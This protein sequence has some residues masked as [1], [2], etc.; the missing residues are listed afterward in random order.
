MTTMKSTLF[1]FLLLAGLAAFSGLDAVQAQQ[2][3]SPASG[4]GWMGV[5]LGEAP[6]SGV[7]I[8]RV[9]EGGPAMKSGLRAGDIIVEVDGAVVESTRG[10]ISAVSGLDSGSWISMKVDRK[11][12]KRELKVRLDGRPE[13]LR[14]LKYREGYI[15][16]DAI[17]IPESLRE[18]FGAP[19]NAGVMVSEVSEGDPAYI[20]GLELGDVIYEVNG[21][22]VRST[23]HLLGLIG[24]GGVENELE[25]RLM[26]HGLEIVLE[27][28]VT[29]TPDEALQAREQAIRELKQQLKQERN[30]RQRRNPDK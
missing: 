28:T 9:L 17:D 26:R 7:L 22:E 2:R 25:I 12:K 8:S 21:T 6:S 10:L 13:N 27:P 24:G 23:R 15:G 18:H 30:Q 29:A 1:S 4:T 16:V 20:A 19:E 11:G 14:T 3:T 5:L